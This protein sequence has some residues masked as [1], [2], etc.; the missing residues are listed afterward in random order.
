MQ[1]ENVEKM[2]EA[3]TL[4]KERCLQMKRRSC[5]LPQLSG[6]PEVIGKVRHCQWGLDYRNVVYVYNCKFKKQTP[7]LQ[8]G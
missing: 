4:E 5:G 7:Y 2:I 3:K 1:I 8:K 6:N